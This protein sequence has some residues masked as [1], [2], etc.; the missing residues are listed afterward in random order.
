MY[1]GRHFVHPVCVHLQSMLPHPSV[2]GH[3]LSSSDL[4]WA[5]HT[6]QGQKYIQTPPD[7]FT[8]A[9][10]NIDASYQ[11]WLSCFFLQIHSFFAWWLVQLLNT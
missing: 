8:A 2:L 11:Y 5:C 9:T 3:L 4:Y 10:L 1:F 6:S 7:T